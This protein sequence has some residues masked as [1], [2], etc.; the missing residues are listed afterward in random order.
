LADDAI[1]HYLDWA[2]PDFY[3]VL[4]GALQELLGGQVT[5][6]EFQT[7]LQDFYAASFS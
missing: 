6:E 3:D 1:G 7:T 5:P 2:A 4:T